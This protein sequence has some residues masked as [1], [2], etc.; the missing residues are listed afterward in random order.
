MHRNSF[1]HSENVFF[2]FWALSEIHYLQNVIP[3]LLVENIIL[4][5][6]SVYLLRLLD[7][8]WSHHLSWRGGGRKEMLEEYTPIERRHW[9]ATLLSAVVIKLEASRARRQGVFVQTHTNHSLVSFKFHELA[10][11]VA[12][13]QICF[14]FGQSQAS[15]FPLFPVFVL[16]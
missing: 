13:M 5:V 7:L 14:T 1:E 4:E 11:K 8:L 16:S 2:F 10:G 12:G 15:S 3:P 6:F 9:N